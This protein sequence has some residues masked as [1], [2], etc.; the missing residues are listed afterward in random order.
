VV[1]YGEVVC[2]IVCCGG[3]WVKWFVGRCGV[4]GLC[5]GTLVWWDGVCDRVV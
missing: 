1:C 4:L 2:V 3:F 5:V